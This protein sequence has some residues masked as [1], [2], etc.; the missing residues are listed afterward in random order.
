MWRLSEQ[1]APVIRSHSALVV[2]DGLHHSRRPE[3]SKCLL[4]D[5][6]EISTQAL[7]RLDE[8]VFYAFTKGNFEPFLDICDPNTVVRNLITL[9]LIQSPCSSCQAVRTLLLSSPHCCSSAFLSFCCRWRNNS[10]G[11]CT[12]RQAG[13]CSFVFGYWCFPV[14]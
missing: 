12:A 8:C 3:W 14:D 11:S 5:E 6:H 1:A 7:R 10:H 2:D 4:N 13:S 9:K